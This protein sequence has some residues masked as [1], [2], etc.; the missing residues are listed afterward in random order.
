MELVEVQELVER[1]YGEADRERGIAPTV[2]WLCE[3]MGELA[4]AVRKGSPDE[5][6]HELGDVLAW[7]ASLANQVG[8]SLDE[9]MQRYVT[10]PP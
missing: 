1:L 3:E 10:D 6:L 4:Q 9:A 8:L 5:Q 2:A 7:L